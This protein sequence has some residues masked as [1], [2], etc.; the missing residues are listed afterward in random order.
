MEDGYGFGWQL[1]DQYED[2]GD[3]YE[4][5]DGDTYVRYDG[6]TY[7]YDDEEDEFVNA[8][9]PLRKHRGNSLM[10]PPS[11]QTIALIGSMLDAEKVQREANKITSDD[12][13]G[14]DDVAIEYISLHEHLSDGKTKPAVIGG[15][16]VLS[17]RPFEQW[18][19]D[20]LSGK[21]TYDDPL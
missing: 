16:P 20:V 11:G 5:E 1:D 4:D 3:V 13:E 19:D 8:N 7:E 2:V 15:S 21:K 6:E 14:A 12:D 10:D 18:V 9:D 17:P